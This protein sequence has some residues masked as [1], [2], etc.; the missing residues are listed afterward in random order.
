MANMCKVLSV[1][2][3]NKMTRQQE[4]YCLGAVGGKHGK[5]TRFGLAMQE[6]HMNIANPYNLCH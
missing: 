5:R 6:V 2:E 4:I 1:S 3:K